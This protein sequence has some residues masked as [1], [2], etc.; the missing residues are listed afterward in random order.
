MKA[1]NFMLTAI[2][3]QCVCTEYPYSPTNLSNQMDNTGSKASQQQ[4][5][6]PKDDMDT[7]LHDLGGSCAT[8]SP[9]CCRGLKSAW[10]P[11]LF[12]C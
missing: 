10:L 2:G 5:S 6:N 8:N 12:T 1:E 4:P 3:G 9:R 7:V 11:S